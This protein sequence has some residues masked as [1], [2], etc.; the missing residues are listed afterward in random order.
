MSA[1]PYGS[2]S[3]IIRTDK[4]GREVWYGKWRSDGR[5]VMRKIGPKRPPSGRADDGLTRKQA[6]AELR[7][8]IAEETKTLPLPGRRVT[9]A[10]AGR[11]YLAHVEAKGRKTSTVSGLESTL[12]LHITPVLGTRW[13]DAIGHEDIADPVCTLQAGGLSPKSIRNYVGALS[14]LFNY[15][16]NPRQ[17][18]ATA[19]PCVGAELPAVPESDEIRFLRLEE[20]DALVRHAIPG[21]YQQ[22]DRALYRTAAMTGLRAGEIVALRLR[23]VDWT[24]SR[25]R[26]RRNYVL[27]E[28]GTP[29]SKRS[30]RSVPMADQVAG[31]RERLIQSTGAKA[32]DALVFPDPFTGEPLKKNAN[33]RR[34]RLALKAAGLD[35]SHR[36][37]DLRHTF[38][39][40]M[41]AHGVPMRT[42]QEMMG[43]R[44]ITTT[45]RY[46]DYAPS[47]GE[48][49]MVA[50][51]FARSEVSD[52]RAE[53]VAPR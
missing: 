11:L 22:L 31:E 37:H 20:V 36:F 4:Q 30:T 21:P 32:D 33:L 18:W 27:G 12:R 47:A 7:C 23:D 42:L 43:H 6:E 45:Q 24:A 5:Q 29:K 1:R 53:V 50:G 19:N 28:F 14:A 41:A 44:D 25:I 52:P 46:A 51:A 3:L 8:V 2:G 49:E 34:M 39:T 9:L 26:V 40:H 16:M 10:E 17:G 35:T 13:L 48:A 38:G 15:A